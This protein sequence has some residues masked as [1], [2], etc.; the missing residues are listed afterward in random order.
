MVIITCLYTTD[1][2]CHNLGSRDHSR[3]ED[4]NEDQPSAGET[5]DYYNVFENVLVGQL[6][7][8]QGNME[9]VFA[10][11][12]TQPRYTTAAK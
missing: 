7:S 10:D 1:L 12:F 2:T 8:R 5:R 6:S 9:A 4:D 11:T 3:R